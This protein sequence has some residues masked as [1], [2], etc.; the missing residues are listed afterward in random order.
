VGHAQVALTTDGVIRYITG[1]VAI[2]THAL[3]VIVNT[4]GDVIPMAILKCCVRVVLDPS[5]V[6][7]EDRRSPSQHIVRVQVLNS[8]VPSGFPADVSVDP[9]DL[10]K[11]AT[12]LENV[13]AW[14]ELVRPFEILVG[15]G[16]EGMV[17][18][19]TDCLAAG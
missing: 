9:D 11:V 3:N 16:P 4:I 13:L 12:G 17:L 5:T 14:R 6:V 15:G 8:E 2:W 18:G 19:G 10:H 1:R 7:N